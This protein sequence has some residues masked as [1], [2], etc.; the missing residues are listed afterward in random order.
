[1]T[2]SE[3]IRICMVVGGLLATTGCSHTPAPRVRGAVHIVEAT[4]P[5]VAEA[6]VRCIRIHRGAGHAVTDTRIAERWPDRSYGAEPVAFAGRVGDAERNM[7]VRFETEALPSDISIVRAKL[8]LHMSVPGGG[9]V[10]GHMATAPWTESDTWASFNG[11][12]LEQPVARARVVP[13]EPST[14]AFDVT[15]SVRTW[16]QGRSNHGLVLRQRDGNTAFATSESDD[17]RERPQLEVCF[18]RQ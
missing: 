11:A 16:H 4:A 17:P 6:G 3:S 14:I 5:V 9:S 8:S 10:S 13:G 18:A 7:L 2:K 15:E 12:F 1:M